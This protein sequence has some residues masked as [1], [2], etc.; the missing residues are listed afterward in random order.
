MSRPAD[1]R[2]YVDLETLVESIVEAIKSEIE[3]VDGI[4]IINEGET[5]YDGSYV[6]GAWVVPGQMRS[7]ISSATSIRWRA[8]IYVI[9][10]NA[11]EGAT[12]AELRKKAYQVFNELAKDPTHG[13]TA[14]VT[15]PRLFHPGYMAFDAETMF[16]GVLMSYEAEFFQKFI[17]DS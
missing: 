12:L 2:E 16:V 7:E 1:P 10:V 8:T 13:G 6:T 15:F 4:D 3:N 17:N 9:L 5:P 11:Q 14:W